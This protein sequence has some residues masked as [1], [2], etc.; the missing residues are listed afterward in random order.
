[1]GFGGGEIAPCWHPGGQQKVCLSAVGGDSLRWMLTELFLQRSLL[2]Q[3][4]TRWP[5]GCGWCN[6]LSEQLHSVWQV[7]PCHV[8]VCLVLLGDSWA[9]AAA[10]SGRK[11]LAWHTGENLTNTNERNELN[12]VCAL[13]GRSFLGRVKW[14]L[15]LMGGNKCPKDKTEC[16]NWRCFSQSCY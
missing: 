11:A 2:T 7:Y 4:E 13:R 8:P 14:N 9:L 16:N 1:M 10:F 12:G 5:C 3:L 6:Q 15:C